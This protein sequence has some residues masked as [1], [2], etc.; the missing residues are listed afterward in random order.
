MFNGECKLASIWLYS[1]DP[2][3]AGRFYRDVLQMKQVEHGQIESFD[4]GGLRLSIHPAPST[5]PSVPNGECFIVF[6]VKNG[7]EQ[8]CDELRKKGVEFIGGI[9]GDPF[10]RSA[11]FKDPDGHEVFLWEPPSRDSKNFK[12]VAGIVDHY[13]GILA[14]LER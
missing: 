1:K 9:D 11:H 6:Y 12:H 2:K 14:K 10:G 4:G 8:R 3:R 13:E 5:M 7:L